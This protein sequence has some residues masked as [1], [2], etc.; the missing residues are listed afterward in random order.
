MNDFRLPSNEEVERVVLGAVLVDCHAHWPMVEHLTADDFSLEAHK[1]IWGHVTTLKSGGKPVDRLTV[2]TELQKY[3]QM[4]SVGG[5]AYLIHLDDGMPQVPNL[6]SYARALVDLRRVRTVI[7]LANNC[8]LRLLAQ[9]DAVSMAE[10][11][12]KLQNI[13][14]IYSDT[15]DDELALMADAIEEEGGIQGLIAGG[16]KPIPTPWES[17]NTLMAGGFRRGDFVILGGRPSDGKTALSLQIAKHASEEGSKTAFFSLET[18]RKALLRRLVAESSGVSLQ[19]IRR[20]TAGQLE[21]DRDT[22]NRIMS[23][24]GKLAGLPLAVNRNQRC[25]PGMI[26]RHSERMK[27][28]D[29]LDVVIVDYLQLMESPGKGQQKRYEI[30]GELSRALKLMAG[31]LDCVVIALAQMGRGSADESRPPRMSDLRE[32][33]NLEQD[34]T[35][36][37]CPY[38]PKAADGEEQRYE[39]HVLKQKDGPIGTMDMDFNAQ[40]MKFFNLRFK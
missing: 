23:A 14:A 20:A 17:L 39:L 18:S 4:E 34:A 9:P 38:R 12:A 11:L 15:G 3:G 28:K 5:L 10:E 8:M 36:V 6:D 1:R 33:G 30:V 27:K 22:R 21:L 2:V 35:V 24:I 29:G 19:V 40:T 32:S 31:E 37:M 26:Y 16:D 13:D 25:S 7:G